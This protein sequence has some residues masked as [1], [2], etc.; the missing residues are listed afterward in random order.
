MEMNIKLWL[1]LLLAS[2]DTQPVSMVIRRY[3]LA[4]PTRMT[5]ISMR[6]AGSCHDC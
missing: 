4:P 6:L 1:A 2:T 5:G 3:S